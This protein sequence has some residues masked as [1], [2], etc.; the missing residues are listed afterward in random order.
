M[1]IC[2]EISAFIDQE[3]LLAE[4]QRLVAAVSGGADSLCL[5]HCLYRLGYRPI[6][7]HLDHQLRPESGSEAAFVQQI[8]SQ[9]GL[10]C[11]SENADVAGLAEKGASIEEAAR[12]LRYRF[13]VHVAQQHG[14]DVI[15]TGH[16]SDDQAETVLMHFLRGAGPSGLRG[17]L[18]KTSLREWV[19]IAEDEGRDLSLVRPLLCVT[20]QQAEEF[21]K[22]LDLSPVLDSSNLD[23]TY[24]RNRLRYHLLPIL[25]KYNPEIRNVLNRT[26]RVMAAEAAWLADMVAEHWSAVV[27]ARGEHALALQTDAFLSLP[28]A[29]QR[30]I[31]REMIHRL[32]P[33]LRDVGFEAVERAGHF[34]QTNERGKRIFLVGNLVLTRCADQFLLFDVENEPLLPEYPQLISDSPCEIP[35]PGTVELE[36]GWVLEASGRPLTRDLRE[37]V[38]SDHSGRIAAM[39]AAK[40]EAALTIRARKPGDRIRPLGMKGTLKVADFFVNHHVPQLVRERWPLVVSG[41]KV[42]WVTGLCMSEDVCFTEKTQEIVMLRLINPA[43]SGDVSYHGN[44]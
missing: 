3:Q 26:G 31:L 1:D 44:G 14:I 39:D 7:A 40:I 38:M 5:L 42:L 10:E 16:T 29:L 35:V 9:L 41:D 43:Q 21:C 19:G 8:A 2:R 32:K 12:I 33:K 30:A 25:E 23:L 6:V 15:S 4:N 24:Y 20:H 28:T 37:K 18:P 17:M 13:L 34:V 22:A 36:S 27:C 11:V